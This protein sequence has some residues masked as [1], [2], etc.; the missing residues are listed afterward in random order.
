M[1][2]FSKLG[3]F[4]RLGNQMFQIAATLGTASRNDT[5]AKFPVWEPNHFFKRDI[6]QSLQLSEI[7]SIY[8]EP[9]YHY[10]VPVYKDGM[11]MQ[12]YFQSSDYFDED[13]IR[14]Q[15]EFIDD[16]GNPEWIKDADSS[17][18]IH[19]RRGD[20]VYLEDYHPFP[21]KGYYEEAIEIIERAETSGF[22]VISDDIP[23]C[24][25]FFGDDPKFFYAEGQSV[26]EDLH[27]MS[28]C[29]HNI[30][31]NSSF[32]WWGA[33]L[34]THTNKRVVAPKQWFG[35]KNAGANTKDLYE[36]NWKII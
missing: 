31:A 19:V 30:I 5:N 13:L 29:K 10:D 17:C 14:T 26:I 22:I 20:Y 9:N 24:R 16:L 36:T 4:G 27:L 2:S 21:G 32:S 23:W 35:H 11:D 33:W 34:N 18:S 7:T 8:K 15:F 3:E 28:K 6:D 1:I 25:T 12:G